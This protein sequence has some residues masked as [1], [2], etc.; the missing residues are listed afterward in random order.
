MRIGLRPS[1]FNTI[2]EIVPLLFDA[3]LSSLLWTAQIV[4]VCLYLQQ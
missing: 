1:L 2:N 3:I 4:A